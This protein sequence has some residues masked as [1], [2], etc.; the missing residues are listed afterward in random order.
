MAKPPSPSLRSM[1][2]LPSFCFARS[3]LRGRRL[4]DVPGA[5][6]TLGAAA[7]QLRAA[8][9]EALLLATNTM[10]AVADEIEQRAELPLLHLVDITAAALRAPVIYYG[11]QGESLDT[12][13]FDDPVNLSLDPTKT[14][15]FDPESTGK[16]QRGQTGL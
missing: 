13:A 2:Y 12:A 8:G 9:A 14:L 3:S 1:T 10:H 5:A 15:F 16:C 11:A 7:A 6:A 4:I